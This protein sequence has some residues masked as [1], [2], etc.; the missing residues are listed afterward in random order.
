MR[1][2]FKGGPVLKVDDPFFNK[3]P[4][5]ELDTGNKEILIALLGI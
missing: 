3:Y 1:L 4:V 2:L 5:L